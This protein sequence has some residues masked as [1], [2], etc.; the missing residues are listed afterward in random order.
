MIFVNSWDS[1]QNCRTDAL[2]HLDIFKPLRH[3]RVITDRPV[4]W[5]R[6]IT[7]SYYTE[8]SHNDGLMHFATTICNLSWPPWR[9]NADMVVYIAVKSGASLPKPLQHQLI[10]LNRKHL[11]ESQD[12]YSITLLSA[13]MIGHNNV[14]GYWCLHCSTIYT[15]L[16]LKFLLVK[17]SICDNAL[18]VP[19]VK[20]W[21]IFNWQLIGNI[22]VFYVFEVLLDCW[23]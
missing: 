6:T 16:L 17:S 21:R 11:L 20:Q 15:D 22:K 12:L 8:K 5:Q 4:W 14:M 10:N 18:Y 13:I 23:F 9:E 3:V 2:S 1:G 7:A 19:S